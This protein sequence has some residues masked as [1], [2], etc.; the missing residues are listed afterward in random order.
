MKT[1]ITEKPYWRFGRW[2]VGVLLVTIYVIYLLFVEYHNIRSNPVLYWL[3]MFVVV[4]GTFI[5]FL[6]F[7][8]EKMTRKL[9]KLL[10]EMQEAKKNH[11]R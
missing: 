7:F 3:S 6:S 4:L 8:L 5:I 10:D 1:R 2:E 11:K 9:N